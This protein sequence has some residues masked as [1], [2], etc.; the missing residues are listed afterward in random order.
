MAP[1]AMVVTEANA[2][3]FPPHSAAHSVPDRAPERPA[4]APPRPPLPNDITGGDTIT[5]LKY[6]ITVSGY[7]NT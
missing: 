3:T 6:D 2:T 7:D 5:I 1:R 4:L